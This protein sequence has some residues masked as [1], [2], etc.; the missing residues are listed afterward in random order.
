MQTHELILCELTDT[1]SAAIESWSPFCLK[2]HRALRAAGL[3]YTRNTSPNPATW[4]EHNPTGQVP[5][6]LV[7][8]QPVADSTRILARIE[9]LGGHT[10][11]PSDPRLRAEALLWEELA[12]TGLNAFLVASRW[13]DA[14]NWP[15]T[16]MA[17]FGG[18]PAPVRAIVPA[19][20]RR[21]VIKA[22]VARDVWRRGAED[23][24]QRFETLLDALDERAPRA[25]FWSGD[26]VGVA[27]VALFG[28]LHA[29]RSE[30]TP[31]QRSAVESRAKL[32]AWLDR[33]DTATRP[34]PALVS[35]A[36]SI[37]A[38]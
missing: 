18:M 35:N 13:A 20:L 2:V 9:T 6:L 33:V 12:D 37:V 38:A 8:G 10:L 27:D 24:W 3:R 5:V 15:A 36:T 22:L 17:Y 23:C 19:L 4:R 28:Q 26:R 7:D 31:W 32:V 34:L 30:L 16:R 29:F 21:N 25:G 14:R 1:G 11:L